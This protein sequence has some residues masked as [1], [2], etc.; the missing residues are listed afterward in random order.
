MAEATT[1]IRDD[2]PD[3]LLTTDEVAKLLGVASAT[4][5]D[6]RRRTGGGPPVTYLTPRLPRYRVG[7]VL[8]W[9]EARR[10]V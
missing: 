1:T 7:D 4:V 5:Y 9:L 3:R 10:D 8:A 2:D 6:W